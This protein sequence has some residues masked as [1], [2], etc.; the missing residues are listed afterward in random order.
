MGLAPSNFP[1]IRGRT[2]RVDENGLIC[3]NDI[4]QAS[5]FTVNKRP[6]DWRDN[7]NTS[8][9]LFAV[10]ERITG[11]SGNWTKTEMRSAVYAKPGAAGGTFADVRLALAYAEY[12][13]PKLAVEV[14]EVFLRYKAADPTLADEV[15]QRASPEA[16]EWAGMRAMG[17]SVRRSYTDTLQ[18]HGCA[19]RDFANC[20]NAIY[21][22]LFDKTA[23]QL[24]KSKGLSKAG[25]LRD[26][27][28]TKELAFVMASEALSSER[29]EE[30]Q[31]DGG[32]DCYFASATSAGYIRQAIEADRKSRRGQQQSLI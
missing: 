18:A 2:V 19:G 22:G 27:M 29:I 11:K 16:N 14:R 12:L 26:N 10:L 24:K 31:C 21:G 1:T 20:T 4:H 25:N 28:S 30:E 17:R 13:S 8:P 9:L 5:G 32:N 3:L 7:P 6:G 23:S 15:L